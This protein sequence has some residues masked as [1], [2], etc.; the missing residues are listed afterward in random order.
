MEGTPWI[1]IKDNHKHISIKYRYDT[2]SMPLLEYLG[3]IAC[4]LS[5]CMKVESLAYDFT[6]S[7]SSKLLKSFN[8][9]F[10]LLTEKF[11][12]ASISGRVREHTDLNQSMLKHWH[13][14]PSHSLSTTC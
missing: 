8:K 7:F 5:K 11:D 2:D 1:C 14:L 12:N 6:T 9:S 13:K 3:F 4:L 10:L